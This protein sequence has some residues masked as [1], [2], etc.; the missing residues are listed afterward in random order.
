VALPA[1]LRFY[2]CGQTV[3]TRAQSPFCHVPIGMVSDP[4]PGTANQS[5]TPIYRHKESI[6]AGAT[7]VYVGLGKAGGC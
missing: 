7:V 4:E 5:V 1:L 3:T 2:A 6:I